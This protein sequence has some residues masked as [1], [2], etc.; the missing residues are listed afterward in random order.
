MGSSTTPQGNENKRPKRPKRP[1]VSTDA[2]FES[3]TY[4]TLDVEPIG[5]CPK[6][7]APLSPRRREKLTDEL[8]AGLEPEPRQY[9]VWEKDSKLTGLGVRI[10]ASGSIAFVLKINLP[11]KRSVW[12][13]LKAK[14]VEAARTEYH[15]ELA[16][17]GRGEKTEKPKADVLWQDVVTR[18]TEEHFRTDIKPT[19]KASYTSALKLLSKAFENRPVTSIKYNDLWIWHLEQSDRKRQANVCIML[20]KVIFSRCRSVWE[21]LPRE[22]LNPVEALQEAGW[23]PYP[24]EERDVR[25]DDEQL[26]QIG[27]ALAQM[28]SSGKESPYPIAAV[29]LLFFSGKRL[30]EILDLQW[31]QIDLK[32]RT[33]VW[34]DSKTGR[35][36]APL[37]DELLLVLQG[38]PRMTYLD[39]EDGKVKEH[40]YVLPG[41]VPGKPIND[42]RKFW[43]R[44][45]KLAGITHVLKESGK[46]TTLRR[47]DLR[48]AHGNE[49]A[50]LDMTLQTI[51]ALLGHRDA[52]TL[53]LVTRRK[54]RTRPSLSPIGSHRAW[55][56]S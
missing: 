26:Q 51:A 30:R 10:G 43:A 52:H 28:E 19:T 53:R 25:L 55:P 41:D 9:Y 38:L 2:P 20:A 40:P 33:I 16:K 32:S 31:D 29:R 46:A 12:K 34:Q 35:M 42:I 44:M 13:T 47:H 1:K 3:D 18:F 48:H 49:G 56:A 17:Y 45:M 5:K 4:Q 11:G 36:K 50:D 14:T 15:E 39:K 22:S 24:E 8:V 54:A 7:R 21:L 27:A 37:N 23:N 6:P